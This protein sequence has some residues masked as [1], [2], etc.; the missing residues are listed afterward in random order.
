[1]KRE[2]TPS[3]QTRL[4]RSVIVLASS[5]VALLV[6]RPFYSN[7]FWFDDSLNSQMRSMLH[8]F[9]TSLLDFS[10]QVTAVWIRNAGRLLLG[11]INIYSM[12]YVLISIQK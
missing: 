12:F 6:L 8:R 2:T 7:G 5:I 11:W 3:N 9:D 10:M 4:F 1:M